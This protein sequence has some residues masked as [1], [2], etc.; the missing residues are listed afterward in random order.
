MTRL[1]LNSLANAW[2][3]A[4]RELILWLVV[5][6]AYEKKNPRLGS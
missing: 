5:V 6:A 1:V 3:E 2:K 4:V